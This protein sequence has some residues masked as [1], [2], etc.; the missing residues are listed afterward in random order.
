M[1]GAVSLALA[2]LLL[3]GCDARPK[4]W[5]GFVYPDRGSLSTFAEIGPFKTFE[6]CQE[7]AIST[8]RAFNAASDGDY[9]CGYRC[10]ANEAYGVKVCK[11]TRK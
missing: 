7:S 11:E 4:V 5:T 9:E 6:A 1:K 3:A 10:G 2:L 8:L